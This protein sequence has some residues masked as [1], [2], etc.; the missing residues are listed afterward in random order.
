MFLLLTFYTHCGGINKNGHFGW[1]QNK[2]LRTLC[3]LTEHKEIILNRFILNI[4]SLLKNTKAI[5]HFDSLEPLEI[6]FSIITGCKNI[7]GFCF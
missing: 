6:L 4:D 2:Y 1:N 5:F 7:S 3:G